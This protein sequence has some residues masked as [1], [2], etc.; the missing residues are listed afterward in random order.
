MDVHGVPRSPCS[1]IDDENRFDFA[2]A[3][4]EDQEALQQEEQEE[5]YD[6]DEGVWDDGPALKEVQ[7]QEEEEAHE[8][9]ESVGDD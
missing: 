3:I 1:S 9:E 4:E 7:Q 6:Y 2:A 8:Y 5:A